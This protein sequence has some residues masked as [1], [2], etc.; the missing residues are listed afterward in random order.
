[1]MMGGGLVQDRV[2]LPESVIG[3][4]RLLS[5]GTTRTALKTRLPTNTLL[6]RDFSLQPSSDGWGG[7]AHTKTA[8][9]SNKP[10]SFISEEGK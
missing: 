4:N 5:F 2:Q 1:M 3:T 7:Y 8:M 9:R 6:L 10:I